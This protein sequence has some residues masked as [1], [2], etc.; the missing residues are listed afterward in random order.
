MPGCQ[1][2]PFM[3]S[4]FVFPIIYCYLRNISTNLLLRLASSIIILIWFGLA[5][6]LLALSGGFY[7]LKDACQNDGLIVA[8][9]ATLI[10]GLGFFAYFVLAGH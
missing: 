6:N 9:I 1:K 2:K 8:V 10:S 7:M 3:G 5:F 4:F